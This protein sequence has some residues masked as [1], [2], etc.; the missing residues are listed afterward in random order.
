MTLPVEALKSALKPLFDSATM[1][2][3]ALDAIKSWANAYASYAQSA[4]AGGTIP[5]TLAP[6]PVAGGFFEAL[7]QTLK[8]MWTATAW[9]G[10][11]LT[12]TT[13][14]IPPLAASLGDVG[15]E[16]VKNREPQKALSAIAD[17]LHTYTLGIKVTVV[18]PAGVSSVVPLM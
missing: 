13:T 14:V 15:K 2:K 8:A 11:G 17:A 7:E 18:T 4:V 3:S 1:P 6:I 5:A 12:G 16:Q 10:P 9:L